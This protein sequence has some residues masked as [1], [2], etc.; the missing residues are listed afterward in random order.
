MG[1]NAGELVERYLLRGRRTG[2]RIAPGGERKMIRIKRA[3]GLIPLVLFA[4]T[5][6]AGL[7][8]E[9]PSQANRPERLL[10]MAPEYPGIVAPQGKEVSMDLAFINKGRTDE[11]VDVKVARTP[12][13]WKAKIKTYRYTVTGVHVPADDKKSLTFEAV[14]DKDVAPGEYAFIVEAQTRDGYFKLSQK[15]NVTLVGDKEGKEQDQ[16]VKLT[17]SYPVIRGPSDAIFEFSVEVESRLDKEAVFDLFAQ[18]PKGWDINFKPAYETKFISSIRLRA[19]QNQSIAVQVKPAPNSPAGEYP[20]I[21]RVASGDARGEANLTVNLTGT[22]EL[23]IGTPSGLLSLEARQG[24]PA[25][26]SFYVKNSGTAANSNIKFMSFKPENWKVEFKPE[27]IDVIEPNG[28]KQVEMIVTPYEDALVGDY[29]IGVKVD[30]E[31]ASKALEF[32]VGVKASTAWGWI[33]IGIIVA[34][35]AGLLGLFRK[36]GRR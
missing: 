2:G 19:S 20:L 32:R 5:L 8:A 11:T 28:L 13:G 6:S 16:G 7:C 36:L 17:T 15:I 23:E 24:Q 22:Y 9:K 31:K 26:V 4:L 34:V 29:S 33:G 27:K 25:N 18:G 30:G 14:P 35:I 3:L 12:A 10:L 21:V 1:V